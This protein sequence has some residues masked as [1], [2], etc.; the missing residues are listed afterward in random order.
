MNCES[1]NKIIFQKY[2]LTYCPSQMRA[3]I[4]YYSIGSWC[5]LP[6]SE[7]VTAAN[8][9]ATPIAAPYTAR[10]ASAMALLLDCYKY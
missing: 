6:R 4:F 1:V 5:P 7:K 3:S 8:A 2:H 9:I 10:D